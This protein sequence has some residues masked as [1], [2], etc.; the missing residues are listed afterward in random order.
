MGERAYIDLECLDGL[1]GTLLESLLGESSLLGELSSRIGSQID[2]RCCS[3]AA[4]PS[5]LVLA[6]GPAPA[7]PAWRSP[8]APPP[9]PS[10]RRPTADEGPASRC[11]SRETE[12]AESLS[13]SVSL[14]AK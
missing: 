3:R 1:E 11:E 8:A 14:I 10:E 7:L 5:G 13:L 4:V 9:P 12:S 2:R 6:V